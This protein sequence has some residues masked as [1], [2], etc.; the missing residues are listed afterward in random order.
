MLTRLQAIQDI[1][2][3]RGIQL[4]FTNEDVIGKKNTYNL[5]IRRSPLKGGSAQ[6][7]IDCRV[8]RRSYYI[9]L[10]AKQVLA[11][12]RRHYPRYDDFTVEFRAIMK[13]VA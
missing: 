3:G 12:I 2:C 11:Y 10:T 1:R 7:L 13:E 9:T 5:I 6:A 8:M 4:T